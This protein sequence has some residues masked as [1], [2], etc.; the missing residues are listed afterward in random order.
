MFFAPASLAHP[1]HQLT[2]RQGRCCNA[3]RKRWCELPRSYQ[4]AVV[5]NGQQSQSEDGERRR[6]KLVE[7]GL[8]MK[9]SNRG[10]S[11]G[12]G[13]AKGPDV[14]QSN[15]LWWPLRPR[16]LKACPSLHQSSNRRH[17]DCDRHPSSS[18]QCP[19]QASCRSVSQHRAPE[20]RYSPP[21]SGQMPRPSTVV[22][23]PIEQQ[24]SGWTT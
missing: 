12:G 22:A 20:S 16:Q 6:T 11:R 24:M 14:C 7:C 15:P 4:V 21:T 18:A 19:S 1:F 3:E 13:R 17:G 2:P 8:L 23:T 10:A 5:A 9:V